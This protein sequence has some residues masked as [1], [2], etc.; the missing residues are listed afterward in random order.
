[1]KLLMPILFCLSTILT[2]GVFEDAERLFQEGKFKECDSLIG[3]ALKASPAEAQKHKLQAMREYI[4]GSNPEK[5]TEN[6]KK[7][8]EIAT[9]RG[10]LT[11]DLLNHS[12]LLIRRAEDWKARGIPE[13]QDLSNA[14]AELLEQLKDGGNP[15]IAI[16]QVI[17]QTRNANLNGEYHE[18]IRRVRNLLRLY[19]PP[20]RRTQEKKPSGEIEL[21]ILLGE[22]YSGLCASTRNEREKINTLSSAVQYYLQAVKLLPENSIRFQDLCDRLCFCRETLRLLGYHLQLPQKIKPRKSTEL[23]MIDEMLR[24]RRFHDVV[25]AL[26]SKSPPSMRLRYATALSAIG[27]LDKAIA[28]IHELKEFP[29]PQFLLQMGKYAI[30]FTDKEKAGVFFQKFLETAPLGQDTIIANQQ[31]AAILV[32]QGKYTEGANVLLRQSKLFSDL[33]QK[34]DTLFLA[35]QYFYRA[36]RYSDCI[37]ILSGIHLTSSRKLLL[38]QAEI[39]NNDIRNA[40]QILN[41]LLKEKSLSSDLRNTAIKLAIFC[42]MKLNSPDAVKLLEEFLRQYPADTES[43]EYAQHLLQLYKKTKVCP[44][45]F[46]KLATF[47]F[48]M[49]PAHHDTTAFLLSCAD[50]IPNT[51]SKGNVFL[52]LLKQKEMSISD[53]NTLLKKIPSLSLKREFWKRYNRPFENVPELCELYF[54]AAEMEFKLRNYRQA[55]TYLEILLQQ[56]EVFQYKSCKR[57]QIETYEKLGQEADVR[58]CCQEL[59]LTQLNAKEKRSIVLLLAQSW[60]RSGEHQKAIASAWSAVPLD[61][62]KSDRKDEQAIRDLLWII[63][64]EAKKIQSKIDIQEAEDI[65]KTYSQSS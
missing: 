53:L 7:A 26:E 32:E 13:Y 37:K 59:L 60:Q 10:W 8:Q 31:Y 55:L 39:K 44:T 57:L 38:A 51:V 43:P 15:A 49:A 25:I 19:Y 21:L 22:Q 61:G 4:W 46:E 14:A 2:A 18:P 11:E 16:R 35:A 64:T 36:E 6:V 3:N 27:K 52:L 65:M 34:E 58:K 20:K 1:M 48:R 29:E 23:L 17:L 40:F 56:P 5:I 30:A 62:N 63:I 50:Q 9:H 33:N 41:E 42:S 54:L 12:T 47:F 24:S 45:K 28:V